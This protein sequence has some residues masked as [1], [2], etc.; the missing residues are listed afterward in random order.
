[1]TQLD[2]RSIEERVA[3]A[4]GRGPRTVRRVLRSFDRLLAYLSSQDLF[5]ALSHF[6]LV[7]YGEN[8][9]TDDLVDAMAQLSELDWDEGDEVTISLPTDPLGREVVFLGD[10]HR[11]IAEE[12]KLSTT[13]VDEILETYLDN[14]PDGIPQLPPISWPLERRIHRVL[15]TAS[16]DLP[17]AREHFEFTQSEY[18][19]SNRTRAD[20]LFTG[21]KGSHLIIELK[22][23]QADI[24]AVHQLAA[25]VELARVELEQPGN[26]LGLLVSFGTTPAARSLVQDD[27]DLYVLP[28]TELGLPW[29]F[30]TP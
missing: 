2:R 16:I 13:V 11:Q 20:A 17:E 30:G 22:R 3:A 1:M 19:F 23:G 27:P 29:E 4:T 5:L 24:A 15:E 7:W 6:R 9:P 8:L 14:C 10:L 18:T 26:V 28:W 25:Y 12:L 21:D